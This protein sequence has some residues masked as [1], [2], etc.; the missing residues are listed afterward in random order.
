MEKKFQNMNLK[1]RLEVLRSKMALTHREI[2]LIKNPC[3]VT[4]FID[5][6]RM[7][8]NA[9]GMY[10]IP[11]GIATNFLINGRNY[12]IPMATEEPS[13]IAAASYAA[14]LASM[15][16]GFK[17]KINKSIMRGQIQ[18]V[19]VKNMQI[20]KANIS[21]NKEDLLRTANANAR[22]VKAI[23]IE[24]KVLGDKNSNFDDPMLIVELIVDTKNAMG[25]NA[26]NSMCELVAPKLERMTQGKVVLKILSNFATERIA[27]CDTTIRKEDLG[28]E[29]TVDRM[30]HGFA[31]AYLD[32][33]RAVTHN[34]G[35]MNGIDAVALA[36]G[37]DFRA[38]EA[39]AHAYASRDGKY[40][41]L[42]TYYKDSN[43]DLGCKIEMPLAV[44]TVGGIASVYAMAKIGLKMLQ[45][46]SAQ[47]LGMVIVAVGL[48]QNI[49]ALRALAEEGIQ[50]GHMKLH[51]RNI[52]IAAGATGPLIDLVAK[53]MSTQSNIT[54]DNARRILE[55]RTGYSKGLNKLRT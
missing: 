55:S 28:G 36:T 44:G 42:S 15:N 33:Y 13:V 18:V 21:E 12:Y 24:T 8:E 23:D 5:L 32:P 16:G 41:P 37:Q 26:V 45:V 19:S 11:L 6:N 54:I 27:T 2:S 52:A 31:F 34:K 46:S 22:T 20:A 49:A 29:K 1:E 38:I 48:A 30:I 9:I 4:K 3:T 40:G 25:A 10:P 17:S 53:K 43:G 47:E 35:I 50:K 51:A 7:I 39:A 14:K